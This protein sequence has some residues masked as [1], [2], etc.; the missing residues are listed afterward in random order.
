MT[1]ERFDVVKVPF[2]FT[3]SS[4]S[5]KRPALVLSGRV[6]FNS[7]V[8]HSVMAM[9]TSAENAP[10]PLD[11][12]IMNLSNAGLPVASVVRMKL[13]TL[14]HRLVLGKIGHLASSDEAEVSRALEILLGAQIVRGK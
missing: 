12:A 3:D 1:Y 7:R 8:A 6:T 11:V 2:P 4:Q 10:W 9:I 14:D 5:K 13:F